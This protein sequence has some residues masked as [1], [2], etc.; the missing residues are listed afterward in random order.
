MVILLAKSGAK[1]KTAVLVGLS[2]SLVGCTTPSAPS[3]PSGLSPLSGGAE[4]R[5]GPVSAEVTVGAAV[6]KVRRAFTADHGAWVVDAPDHRAHILASGAVAFEPKAFVRS[7]RSFAASL[8]GNVR[9]EAAPLAI[10]TS[11]IACGGKVL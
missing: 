3:V 1:M 10:E 6:S 2:I 8:E 9:A 7:R 5:R 11:A 4:L